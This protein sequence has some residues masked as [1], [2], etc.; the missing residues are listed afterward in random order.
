MGLVFVDWLNEN[1]DRAYPVNEA[2]SRL[3]VGSVELPNN[4]I[5][6]ANIALPRSAGRYVYISSIGIT[7]RL[8]TMT[9]L[10]SENG[11]CSAPSSSSS[12]AGS[13]FVPIG[14]VSISR[15]V[16]RFKNYPIQA[17]YPGVAGWVA[18]GHGAIDITSLSLRFDSISAT[19]LV[20]RAVRVY[21]DTPVLS[22]G[23]VDAMAALTGI[24]GVKGVAGTI[25]T[26]KS[27]RY[28][29][30]V[31]RDVGVIALDTSQN[32]VT[33]LQSFAGTC[34]HRPQVGTCKAAPI[35]S[36]NNVT[37]DCDGNIDLQFEGEQLIGD[38][39]DGEIIDFPIGLSQ[40]CPKKFVLN[41]I[42]TDVCHP[43]SSSSSSSSSGSSESSSS[44]SAT[45]P[46]ENYCEDFS[47]GFGE[48]SPII[49][50][51]SVASNLLSS[52]FGWGGEQY[53]ID[54][55]RTMS[56]PTTGN[57]YIVE[58]DIVLNDITTSE[59]HIIL[60]YSNRYSFTFVG[61]S[62]RPIPAYP[63]TL[64]GFFFVGHRNSISV[65]PSMDTGYNIDQIY[66]PSVPLTADTYR[67]LV[68]AENIG[69]GVAV[70]FAVRW[71]ANY[72]HHIFSVPTFNPYGFCGLGVVASQTD[73]G[74]FGINCGASSSS[75]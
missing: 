4:I 10:A 26:S 41:L 66:V 52:Q 18:F 43:S 64:N 32:A 57:T 67:L 65:P 34:G 33:I 62:L 21:H 8:V 59:G 54:R 17:M 23:S 35:T 47:G 51:W 60:G 58:S 9:L 7:S 36:I 16:V 44:S 31:L 14:V 55:L 56:I 20:D 19:Q 15:P 45:P 74:N 3:D 1:E 71:G 6:D 50:N 46:T 5:V 24:V 22:L 29:D 75:L 27:Q 42:T 53:C 69:G 63:A 61:I 68:Q 73:F 72:N 40:I 28:I 12:S 11:F 70:S 37:P 38:T 13:G 48:L 49:G 30:G 2:A 39:G 25:K